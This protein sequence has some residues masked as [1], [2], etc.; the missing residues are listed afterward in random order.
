MRNTELVESAAGLGAASKAAATSLGLEAEKFNLFT[1][2]IRHPMIPQAIL[3]DGL[4]EHDSYPD[5]VRF[6]GGS[7]SSKA[8]GLKFGDIEASINE[9]V[10]G[11][12]QLSEHTLLV[13]YIPRLLT[14]K[15]TL[16]TVDTPTT[17]APLGE[18]PVV[19]EKKATG[20]RF[21]KVTSY[22]SET[23]QVAVKS[24]T[25]Y[26]D[27]L[28]RNWDGTTWHDASDLP[29]EML[30][31]RVATVVRTIKAAATIFEKIA[32]KDDSGVKVKIVHN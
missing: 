25:S 22:D 8:R 23:G 20:E 16:I 7:V 24:G 10:E 19:I 17:H 2:E 9:P 3:P 30:E 21:R 11:K 27:H 18:G 4:A 15:G 13:P 32:M 31:L 12:H 1:G 14:V 26:T 6:Y 28:M 5:V 29:D